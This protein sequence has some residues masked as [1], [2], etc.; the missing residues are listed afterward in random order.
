MKRLIATL[1]LAIGSLDCSVLAQQNNTQPTTGA[2]YLSSPNLLQ[3]TQ[4]SW[5]NTVPGSNGGTSGGGT[6]AA[7]NASTNTII[8][9]YT[10][11]TVA[12]TYAFNQALQNAGLSIGGYDYSWK[13][14]NADSNT[15][16]L[17]GKFTLTALN[18]TALQTYNYTYNDRT[19]GESENFQ[20]FSGTQWFPQNHLSSNISGFTM[21]W[22]GKDS[23]F[24]AGYYGPRVREP[25]IAL[26]YLVDPCAA[27]PLSSP[28]C[29]GYAAALTQRCAAEPLYNAT[30]PGYAAAYMTQQCTANPL[31]NPS[32][33]GYATAYLNYQCSINPLYST[34][35]QGYAEAKQAQF[36]A[37]CERDALYD[38]KCPGYG[39]AYG[40]R[41]V[42]EQ[43]GIASTVAVAGSVAATKA[44]VT[45]EGTVS[46]T[47]NTT[48]DK[49]LAPAATTA[50]SAAAPAAPVQLGQQQ[51][52]QQQPQQEKK[53]EPG[54]QQPNGQPGGPQGGAQP[55]E[56]PQEPTN[57]TRL[58]ETRQE[59]EKKQKAEIGKEMVKELGKAQSMDEQ[60]KVQDV[61]IQ[62][63][64]YSPA[65]DTYNKFIMPD[66]VGYKPFAVYNNQRTVDNRANLRM[67]GGAD[68]LHQEMVNSQYNGQ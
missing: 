28:S 42:L 1:L 38:S 27:D 31:Y 40:K 29:P 36:L 4:G 68:R 16:T 19:S 66:G 3:A 49:A 52:Q 7:F 54:Q 24:W 41:M 21:E 23:R 26:R 44:T 55:N 13:I 33:P 58:A 50:N 15:G 53:Q 43:Q 10:T 25:S 60:R 34:T 14:N 57:R 20:T 51:P 37:A 64:G 30:C 2:T 8:F 62:A 35:C 56:R 39:A 61:V 47:G 65:F 18:G 46:T 17:S 9:G 48:V 5:T 67:F 32:C 6:A 45:T 63:M 12:Q 22:T 11:K 59:S